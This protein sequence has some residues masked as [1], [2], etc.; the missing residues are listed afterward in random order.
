MKKKTHLKSI[1]FNE[2]VEVHGKQLEGHAHVV[3][4]AEALEHM[5]E[6]HVIIA[7]LNYS[8]KERGRRVQR[9]YLSSESLEDGDFFLRLAMEAFFVAHDF[10]GHVT[11]RLV[12]EGFYYLSE[13]TLS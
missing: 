12:V 13:R 10:Q 5:H 6:V 1:L 3:S 9:G 2:F 4:E 8:G 7:I 11:L